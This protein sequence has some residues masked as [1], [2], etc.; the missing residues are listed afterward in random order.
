MRYLESFL[1][2]IL[3]ACAAL[4][5]QVFVGLITET[6]FH[7]GLTLPI[8]ASSLHALVFFLIAATIE[9]SLR[10]LIIQKRIR[11]YITPSISPTLIHGAL[12]GAGFWIFE[13]I[14]LFT[15]DT[16]ISQSL[17]AIFTVLAIHVIASIILITALRHK[18]VFW[19][20]TTLF[21]TILFHALANI[22]ILLTNM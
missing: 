7:S 18:N 8:N 20:T 6:F 1:L 14:L 12:L 13:T 11:T 5:A 21:A 17:I 2:G 15:R 19:N 10:F 9:E 22:A 3:I 4:F 16:E